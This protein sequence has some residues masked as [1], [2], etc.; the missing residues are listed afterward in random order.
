MRYSKVVFIFVSYF[1]SVPNLYAK[2]TKIQ[3]VH[4]FWNSRLL[5]P[6]EVE[7]N[8]FPL[9]V[10]KFGLSENFE[11]GSSV[12]FLIMKSP[13]LFIKH[14]MFSLGKFETSLS[15]FS[16]YFSAKS[17]YPALS[18]G[19]FSLNGILSTYSVNTDLSVNLGVQNL[20]ALLQDTQSDTS[21]GEI[22]Q[23]AELNTIMPF[24][25]IDYVISSQWAFTSFILLPVYSRIEVGNDFLGADITKLISARDL[26]QSNFIYYLG[27][28]NSWEVFNLEIGLFKLYQWTI[29][30]LAFGWRFQ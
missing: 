21:L 18:Q 5:N 30:Y 1:L 25:G 24:L 7:I 15:S 6:E 29:P 19:F 17:L 14:R 28:T 22:R 10:V 2:F 8:A 26:Q 9:G 3:P 13:S 16:A 11:L 12:T 4:H 23:S 27:V 20:Y